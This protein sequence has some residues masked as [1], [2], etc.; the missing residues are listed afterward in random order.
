M[1]KRGCN[2]ITCLTIYLYSSN[3]LILLLS[4]L[5]SSND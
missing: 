5:I 1:Y 4:K 3:L 2:K